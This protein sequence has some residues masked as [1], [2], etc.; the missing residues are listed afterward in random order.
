MELFYVN[1][2]AVSLGA[3]LCI[4]SYVLCFSHILDFISYF[5]NYIYFSIIIVNKTN[6]KR[7]DGLVNAA[8]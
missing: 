2:L 4:L 3:H 8:M 5:F 7:N 1:F 6:E